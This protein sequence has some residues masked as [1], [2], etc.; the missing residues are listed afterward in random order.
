MPKGVL[1]HLHFDCSE[2]RAF[3]LEISKHPHV[4]IDPAK[5]AWRVANE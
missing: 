5:K 4:Y 2:S 1:H 3:L